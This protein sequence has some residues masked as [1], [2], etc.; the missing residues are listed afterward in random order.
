MTTTGFSV[1]SADDDETA[2]VNEGRQV[3]SKS[4]SLARA[5]EEEGARKRMRVDSSYEITLNPSPR[6]IFLITFLQWLLWK[7]EAYLFIPVAWQGL[8]PLALLLHLKMH[9]M[10]NPFNFVLTSQLINILGTC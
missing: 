10:T 5:G 7:M 6:T 9:L 4:P 2:R 1:V 3:S 8:M